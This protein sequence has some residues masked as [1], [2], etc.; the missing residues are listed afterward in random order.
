MRAPTQI[1]A[2]AALMLGACGGNVLSTAS[3]ADASGD[4]N[5]WKHFMPGQRIVLHAP[6]GVA[7][8]AVSGASFEE[9]ES[10]GVALEGHRAA[11][12][13]LL[14]E[15]VD[16]RVKTGLA[17]FIALEVRTKNG[18]SSWLKLPAGSRCDCVL[19]APKG[20]DEVVA[21]EGRKL[22]FLPWRPECRELA[23]VGEAPAAML[24]DADPGLAFEVQSFAVGARSPLARREGKPGGALWLVM[25]GGTLEVRAD[26]VKSCFG[27]P[28]EKRPELITALIRMPAGRCSESDDGGK[29][30]IECRSTLGAWSGVVA[31]RAL[32]LRAVRRSLGAVH[33]VD[34]QPVSGARYAKA[35]VA[36]TQGAAADP[37]GRE[38]YR[39]LDQ[40][41]RRAIVSD[42]SGSVRISTPGAA[43]VTYK[44]HVEVS[45]LSIGPLERHE[46]TDQSEYKIRDDVRD[47]PDKPRARERVQT[48]RDALRDA[49]QSYQ[50]E[51]RLWEQAKQA[52][53]DECRRQAEQMKSDANRMM[54]SSTCDIASV[55]GQLVK[56]GD[57]ALRN[58]RS[59]LAD[60]ES[61]LAGTPDTITVPIMGSWT[62]KKTLYRRATSAQLKLTMQG[63]NDAQPSV[64]PIPLSHQWEDYEVDADPAHNVKG[65]RPEPRFLQSDDALVPFVAEKASAALAVRLRAAL[66]Q[67]AIEQA[68]RAFREAGNAPPKPG[69][70]AVDAI[71]F[72]TAGRRLDRVVLRGEATLASGAPFAL[73]VRSAKPGA[74]SCLLA[75]AVAETGSATDLALTAPD[76][77]VAD[78]RG[79]SLALVEVCD[80]DTR[81][82]EQLSLASKLG[83]KARWGLYLTRADAK[84]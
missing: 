8:P 54:A 10:G 63:V 70:E 84:P 25:N 79:G 43:D 58:A 37:R 38:L 73:P 62:Y 16:S 81:P 32:D 51:V 60:A 39:A 59:E 41:V 13:A 47:N 44:L 3:Y 19:A 71:A 48:A 50:E 21:L 40:S 56:P 72:E 11:A 57:S 46:T 67:A 33:F 15:I 82:I 52:A 5:G 68:M 24:I 53:L 30:H 66:S 76:G 17:G 65:N 80:G 26:V 36:V 20:V 18:A 34:G 31:D 1:A 78:L 75:V 64:V 22:A 45:D 6:A 7:C 49:E 9:I 29:R 23:A 27:A 28:D 12:K 74:G 42:G 69:F 2:L 4:E 55:A 77:A 14:F 83:G 35:V 61:T